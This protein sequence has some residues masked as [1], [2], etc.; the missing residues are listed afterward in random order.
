METIEFLAN[1]A[2]L[3]GVI[4]GFFEL[5]WKDKKT[6]RN[7]VITLAAIAAGVGFLVLIDL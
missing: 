2:L 6:Y 5:D 7:I 1:A 4:Y 3:I